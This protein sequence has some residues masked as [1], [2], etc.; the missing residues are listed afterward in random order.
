MR[1]S[2]W[3]SDVCSSDL[4]AWQE[5]QVWAHRREAFEAFYVAMLRGEF[6]DYK[7]R[8]RRWN[9]MR[10]SFAQAGIKLPDYTKDDTDSERV[11]E[12]G[13]SAKIG[14][15]SCREQVGKYV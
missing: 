7:E 5:G 13:N 3:S 2:D 6:T 14:R 12:V 15:A 1:I 9:E 4:E 11:L 10:R 8:D